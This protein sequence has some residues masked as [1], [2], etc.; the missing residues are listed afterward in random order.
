MTPIISL[1]SALSDNHVIGNKGEIPWHITDDLR[2]FKKLTD[3]KTIIVGRKTFDL[4]LVAYHSRGKPLPKRQT[5]IITSDITYTTNEDDCYIVH[6]IKEAIELGKKIESSELF[7]AG[8]ASIYKQALK[9]ADRL[10]L[11]IVHINTEGDAF[12]PEYEK[13]FRRI[14]SKEDHEENGL[15]FSYVTFEK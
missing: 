7:I 3:G 4:L 8:G 10:L 11:T 12:F 2:R 14:I 5:I 9:F 13:E 1:I 15:K 6:S